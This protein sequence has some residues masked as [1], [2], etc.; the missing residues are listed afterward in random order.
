MRLRVNVGDREDESPAER[1][2]REK[3]ERIEQASRDLDAVP[4]YQ[5]LLERFEGNTTSVL[6]PD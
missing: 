1:D 5:D 6:P 3:K 4:D 2:Q